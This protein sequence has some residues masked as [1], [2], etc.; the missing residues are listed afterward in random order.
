MLRVAARLGRTQCRWA[1]KAAAGSANNSGG[2][3][4]PKHRGVKKRGGELVR[5]NQII[6]RQTGTHWHPGF[7][8]TLARD[9]SV[10][11][12]CDGIVRFY[13]PKGWPR[14]STRKFIHVVPLAG[15]PEDYTLP[16]EYVR[17]LAKKPEV[18]TKIWFTSWL[19]DERKRRRLQGEQQRKEVQDLFWSAHEKEQTEQKLEKASHAVR[20]QFYAFRVGKTLDKYTSA[21]L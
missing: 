11:A 16:S 7:N 13:Q 8:T 18:V 6:A 15:N 3:R 14:R 20:M 9:F 1:S 12:N 19:K 17:Q 2:S 5:K 4:I 10:V 21:A